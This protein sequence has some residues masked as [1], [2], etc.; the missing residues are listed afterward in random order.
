M[1]K[2]L[3]LDIGLLDSISFANFYSAGNQQVVSCL[4][5]LAGD[6]GEYFVYLWGSRGCGKTHL[7]QAACHLVANHGGTPVYVPL[8]QKEEFSP[9]VLQ[10]L[11]DLS[12]VAIDDVQAVAAHGK[13]E[14]ALFYLYNRVRERGSRLVV[15]GNTSPAGLG[16]TLPDLSSRLAWGLVFQIQTLNDNDKTTALKMRAEHR[17]FDLPDEVAQ[18]LLRRCSRDM[19]SLFD[20]LD[21]LDIASLA[22]HRRL[23]IPFVRNIIQ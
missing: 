9:E 19:Q 21:Q 7:L 3:L 5:N 10:G 1:A 22:E 23:T 18:Y 15:A 20:L 2:Q 14:E 16:L 13:W 17:G 6:N 8:Q 11:E 12:L 4:K